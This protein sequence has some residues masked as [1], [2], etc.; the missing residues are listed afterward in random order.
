M[1]NAHTR[2]SRLVPQPIHLMR[3]HLNTTGFW[4]EFCIHALYSHTPHTHQNF[5]CNFD[6]SFEWWRFLPFMLIKSLSDTFLDGDVKC[7]RYW[8]FEWLPACSMSRPS[9]LSHHSRASVGFTNWLQSQFHVI[10]LLCC[11]S[12]DCVIVHPVSYSASLV[13]VKSFFMSSSLRSDLR[14]YLI[15]FW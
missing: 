6:C 7:W 11:S 15:T 3:W 14:F 10:V 12:S 1:Y 9:K 5:E 13:K 8:S 4:F 2:L